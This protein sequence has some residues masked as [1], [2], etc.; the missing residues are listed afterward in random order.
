[1]SIGET[2]ENDKD[3]EEVRNLVDFDQQVARE[4]PYIFYYKF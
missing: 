3:L 4:C 1:M 2:Y